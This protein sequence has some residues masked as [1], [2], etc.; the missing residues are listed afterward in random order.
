MTGG[1]QD[2]V[3]QILRGDCEKD[4]EGTIAMGPGTAFSGRYRR[5]LLRSRLIAL[6]KA[7]TTDE[8]AD[9]P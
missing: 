9:S 7:L 2:R 1:A 3:H 4:D 6:A 8:I 5:D